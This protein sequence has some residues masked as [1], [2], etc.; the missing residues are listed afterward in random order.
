VR[1]QITDEDEANFIRNSKRFLDYFS[2]F[3]LNP[4]GASPLQLLNETSEYYTGI[5]VVSNQQL[6]DIFMV[7][8]GMPAGPSMLSVPP[9]LGGPGYQGRSTGLA[10]PPCGTVK[11]A[12]E[13]APA[14]PETLPAP[15]NTGGG[16]PEM[17]PAPAALGQRIPLPVA[18]E[19]VVGIPQD[20][21]FLRVVEAGKPQ[22]QLRSG[23]E[24][25]S[26]FLESQT[27]ASQVLPAFRQG[28]Q[29]VGR[30][31]QQIEALELRVM[32]TQGDPNLPAA[33]QENH[34]EIRPGPD[35]TRNQFKVALKKLEA[36]Q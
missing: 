22:F 20:S 24:G 21:N 19:P 18:E 12:L 10:E 25:L 35:M 23:E 16:A 26:V 7:M 14:V 30:T 33:L 11:L 13:D 3:G 36:G 31:I 1:Q 9:I 8:P 27:P 17:I 15:R 32:R 5:P 4:N 34:F 28:S 2:S 6:N 29:A